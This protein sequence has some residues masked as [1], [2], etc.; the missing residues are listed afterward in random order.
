MQLELK[1]KLV[2]RYINAGDESFFH[3]SFRNRD[4][5][6]ARYH[7]LMERSFPRKQLADHIR[8]FMG[9][10]TMTEQIEEN[11]NKLENKKSVVVI[12]GQ[13]A[14]LLTGPLYSIHKMISI[15]LLAK[16]QERI[17]QQP[18]VPIFWIAG[19]DH[20]IQEVNHVYKLNGHF[21]VKSKFPQKLQSDKRMI[22]KV[23]FDKGEMEE[24]YKGVLAS[25]KETIYTKEILEFL[26]NCLM[27]SRT[28]TD[29]FASI[30]NELFKNYGLLLIDSAHPDLRKIESTYFQL[31]IEYSEQITE[32][33]MNKQRE[34]AAK[35]Y[36]K[37]IDA[38][39]SSLQLFYEENDERILLHYDSK[40]NV[41]LGKRISFTKDEL[42]EAV[43]KKPE[44]FSNNVVTR[45]I[46]QELLFPTI[47]FVAGPGEIA[48]WA[49]LKDCFELLDL[50]VPLIFPRINITYLERNIE[51]ELTDLHFSLKST[52]LNGTKQEKQEKIDSLKN[53]QIEMRVE[54]VR[55]IIRDQYEDL[56]QMIIDYDSGLERIVH[57]NADF[58][59]SQLDFLQHKTEESLK[60]KY[61]ILLSKFDRINESLHPNDGFQERCWNIF[62]F[63]NRYGLTFIDSVSELPF[64]CNGNHYIVKL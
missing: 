55:K 29:F 6:F 16:Q 33:L 27:K 21:L 61:E 4:D 1:N 18:V 56:A 60:K 14:G 5:L 34:L 64:E 57:K 42:I 22:S 25:F 36:Q 39:P 43:R 47:S 3:Y 23:E 7:E 48:Y 38:S 12:G 63:L 30:V 28:Y 58:V 44:K 24:W 40:E 62:Y 49:E 31:M 52:L 51:S 35:G 46:M 54:T 37:T 13:Q 59:L 50:K 45:P 19:E 53:K 9:T 2:D 11:L 15:I 20:D 41:V 8:N 17:L 32:R 26:H 10:F